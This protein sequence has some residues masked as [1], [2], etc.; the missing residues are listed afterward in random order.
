MTARGSTRK[1]C[2][3]FSI[4]STHDEKVG[5][6]LGLSIAHRAVQAHGG[7]LIATSNLGQGATFA[8]VLPRRTGKGRSM[9]VEEAEAAAAPAAMDTEDR[10]QTR[11]DERAHI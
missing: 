10:A 1:T 9:A 8:M 2:R 5:S 7:A 6:G 11:S 4:R 3:A